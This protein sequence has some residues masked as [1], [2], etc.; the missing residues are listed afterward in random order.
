MYFPKIFL[1]MVKFFGI[2]TIDVDFI[3]PSISL[4]FVMTILSGLIFVDSCR[5]IISSFNSFMIKTGLILNSFRSI[6][7][8]LLNIS[9]LP[10]AIVLIIFKTT[11]LYKY[12]LQLLC[13]KYRLF[14]F[15]NLP[16]EFKSF[17]CLYSCLD[18]KKLT[19][20]LNAPQTSW[21]WISSKLCIIN[22][23]SL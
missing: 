4:L 22:F 17:S 1:L 19:N 3:N 14:S 6:K 11:T 10:F 7:N 16:N 12:Q 9:Y 23:H 13:L 8:I 5:Q 20:Y 15:L 18:A 2:A 21:M